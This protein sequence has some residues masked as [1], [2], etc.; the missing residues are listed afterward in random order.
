MTTT[1]INGKFTVQRQTGVQRVAR[2]LVLALDALA[3]AGRWILLRPPGGGAL[4]LRCIEQ[5]V[6]RTGGLPLHL[7]EQV[8][9]PWEARDG[10]L[11]SLAGSTPLLARRQAAVLHDAAVFDHP[12][13][14]T[15]LFVAWYR[16][17]F[18][19]LAR[20]AERLFTVSS[21][22]EARLSSAL[23][24]AQGRFT[25]LPNGCDH[26]R[27]I[28]ADPTCLLR[29]GLVARR[30]LLAVASA[31]PTKNLGALLSAFATLPN[32]DGL[33]L[34]I[35]G[36]HNER[37]FS[38]AGDLADPPGVIRTGALND[39]CLKALYEAAVALV[40][41]SLYE[42]FGLPPLEAMACGCP[43]AAAWAASIPEVCGEAARYFD[44]VSAEAMAAAMHDVL[45]DADLRQRLLVL[46]RERAAS[47]SWDRPAAL[48]LKALRGGGRT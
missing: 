18:R 36:G 10:L 28:V 42:G 5:R 47:Y 3:P 48:L 15:W 7:W 25:V 34:V 24:V 39:R 11:L 22:S 35:V 41:P 27:A 13:A 19:R 1:Y 30:F 38:S 21:F 46:G 23:L 37:V 31:N 2:E 45:H 32:A 12:H 4:K 6:V 33:L 40:F 8:A 43:V 16:M 9:L 20:H 29:H 26:M 17:L 44:P 14:Y